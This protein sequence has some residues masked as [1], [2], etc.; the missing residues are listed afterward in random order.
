MAMARPKI[1]PTEENRF[2]WEQA[3]EGRL[4]C[5]RCSRCGVLQHPPMPLCAH[6]LS[7][8]LE[9]AVLSGRGIVYAFTSVERVFHPGF[10]DRLP[11]T[12][13]LVELAEQKDLRVLSRIV[14]CDCEEVE[15]GMPVQVDFEPLGD[16][17]LPVFRREVSR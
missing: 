8:E 15:I 4:A 1:I 16:W 5:R 13:A 10:A 2:F 17:S 3:R 9:T 11:Y 12:L 6:C 7:D 14:G